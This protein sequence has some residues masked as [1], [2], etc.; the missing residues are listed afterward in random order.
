MT[1][2]TKVIVCDACMGFGI[3]DT[4]CD[5]EGTVRCHH[6]GGNG[7]IET[8]AQNASIE[9]DSWCVVT[10]PKNVQSNHAAWASYAWFDTKADAEA[11]VDGYTDSCD[12]ALI[13]SSDEYDDWVV[14]N[15][16]PF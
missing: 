11:D 6:C 4:G 12:Y 16:S 15:S 8:E 3:L 13:L 10:Y 7:T 2:T 9:D 14:A 5:V 1:E